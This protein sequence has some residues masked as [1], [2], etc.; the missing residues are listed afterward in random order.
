MIIRLMKR[1]FKK[2]YIEP[3]EGL[4][5]VEGISKAKS[6]YRELILKAHPDRHATKEGLAK[7]LT[8]LIN[9]HK[10]NY[11]EL[12]KLKERVENELICSNE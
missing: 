12:V 7:E 4:N 1:F 6:L 8:E 9:M 3:S 5:V 11:R 2:R 10:Y